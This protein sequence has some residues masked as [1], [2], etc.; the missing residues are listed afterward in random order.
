MFCLS[1]FLAL[2]IQPLVTQEL[3]T[4]SS[5]FDIEAARSHIAAILFESSAYVVPDD[6]SDVREILVCIASYAR[7]LEKDLASARKSLSP[8]AQSA[9]PSPPKSDDYPAHR[10]P[11]LPQTGIPAKDGAKAGEDGLYIDTSLADNLKHL[12][13]DAASSRFFGESS[14][15]VLVKAAMDIKRENTGQEISPLQSHPTRRPEYWNAASV[16]IKCLW[17]SLI[18]T[19]HSGRFQLKKYSRHTNSRRTISSGN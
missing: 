7:Q 5:D 13:I 3:G 14:S 6:P 12:T 17:A 10:A 19:S 8:P 1:N 2:P 15:V 4:H 16:S 9:E 11:I 18:L